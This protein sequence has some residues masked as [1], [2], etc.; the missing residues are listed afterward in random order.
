MKYALSTSTPLGCTV[1]AAAIL[2]LPVALTLIFR[3][4]PDVDAVYLYLGAGTLVMATVYLER[5]LKA[6]GRPLSDESSNAQDQRHTG[7]YYL[8]CGISL[9]LG[10]IMLAFLGASP[11]LATLAIPAAVLLVLA[12][13]ELLGNSRWAYGLVMLLLIPFVVLWAYL[14]MA[15]LES[16]LEIGDTQQMSISCG[17]AIAIFGFQFYKWRKAGKQSYA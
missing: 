14:S 5:G 13:A 3:V 10:G 8:A 2:L 11:C 12:I 16:V 1:V 17:V 15:L 4:N 7:E 6:S 9:I